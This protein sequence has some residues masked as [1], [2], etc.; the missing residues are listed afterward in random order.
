MLH[1]G[2]TFPPVQVPLELD[3]ARNHLEDLDRAVLAA[4]LQGP[5]SARGTAGPPP[6]TPGA[7]PGGTHRQLGAG[8]VGHHAPDGSPAAIEAAGRAQPGQV[9]LGDV[10]AEPGPEEPV[11]GRPAQRLHRPRLV[12]G[13]HLRRDRVT[14]RHRDHPVPPGTDGQGQITPG[15]ASVRLD[16]GPVQRP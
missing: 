14:P 9:V 10:P 2:P 6:R 12:P 1:P 15:T 13:D 16:T 7:A 5:G 3:P 8:A 11:P 4:D